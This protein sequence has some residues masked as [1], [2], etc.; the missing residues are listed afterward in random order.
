MGTIG[1]TTTGGTPTPLSALSHNR[2]FNALTHRSAQAHSHGPS[3]GNANS[4]RTAAI[5]AQETPTL[6]TLIASLDDPTQFA[7][8]L[9]GRQGLSALQNVSIQDVAQ[10]LFGQEAQSNGFTQWF[11]KQAMDT[12]QNGSLDSGEIEQYR[13]ALAKQPLKTSLDQA[14]ARQAYIVQ[15]AQAL[16]LSTQD[17]QQLQQRL[18]WGAVNVAGESLVNSFNLGA[19]VQ[20]TQDSGK[21]AKAVTQ[22]LDEMQGQPVVQRVALKTL[23]QYGAMPNYLGEQSEGRA[24]QFA[25][26]TYSVQKGQTDGQGV[27]PYAVTEHTWKLDQQGQ[28]LGATGTQQAVTPASI[29]MEGAQ[30]TI[31]DPA[32]Y[33]NKLSPLEA[34]THQQLNQL[35][36]TPQT[37]A[38][39]RQL[40]QQLP[41]LLNSNNAA[42]LEQALA[43]I[44]AGIRQV[45]GL[46]NIPLKV[47]SFA[48]DATLQSWTAY[49][50]SEKKEV[51]LNISALAGKLKEGAMVGQTPQQQAVDTAAY[52][53]SAVG[54]EYL[55]QQQD[56]VAERPSQLGLSPST[57]I[58]QD[59]QLN[60]KHYVT[61]N[62]SEALTGNSRAYKLQPRERDANK[63]QPVLVEA[64][65]AVSGVAR[66]AVS[67][68]EDDWSK[69]YA[70]LI[71]P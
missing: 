22:L 63:V 9:T 14:G 35:I 54:H 60:S 46:G 12:N 57:P 3:R 23:A 4:D 11:V 20:N 16:G 64:V 2:P 36:R 58:V 56:L 30:L 71:R 40:I 51:V 1:S 32:S 10:Q 34:Q 33:N 55:H 38:Q 66:P 65:W 29:G 8:A 45:Y 18:S 62:L 47:Q 17:M 24:P 41:N 52:I 50:D 61:P 70:S 6:K 48:G 49:S 68:S 42:G 15:N 37:T 39:V 28:L 25:L 19:E 13:Q 26:R 27:T 59:Y 43:P 67:V 44:A 53:I 69:D 21:A 7:Q 31:K 5:H